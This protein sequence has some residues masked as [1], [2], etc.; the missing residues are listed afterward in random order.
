VR[1][2]GWASY[3]FSAF[4]IAVGESAALSTTSLRETAV[5][6]CLLQKPQKQR[7]LRQIRTGMSLSFYARSFARQPPT[8]TP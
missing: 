6:R 1:S 3:S 2:L 8:Q 5:S 4:C 7:L